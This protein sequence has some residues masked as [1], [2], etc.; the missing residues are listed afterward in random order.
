MSSMSCDM[1]VYNISEHWRDN[2]LHTKIVRR[3]IT[4]DY[5]HAVTIVALK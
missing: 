2:D 5:D 3:N 1:W 4:C